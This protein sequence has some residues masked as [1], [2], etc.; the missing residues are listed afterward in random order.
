MLV[1]FVERQP[2]AFEMC[3]SG[4]TVR[5]VDRCALGLYAVPFLNA[6]TLNEGGSASWRS[7]SAS[8]PAPWSKNSGMSG[9]QVRKKVDSRV[10][11]ML[12]NLIAQFDD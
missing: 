6:A 8:D 4:R 3:A 9:L 1:P 11:E 7:Y 10:A 5:F 12:R 2:R